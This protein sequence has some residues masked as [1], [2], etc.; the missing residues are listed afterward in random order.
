ME[1]LHFSRD[2]PESITVIAYDITERKKM[3]E[4]LR[5]SEKKF[6]E[7]VK[8]APTAIYELDFK[9]RKFTTVN[10]AMCQLSGYSREELLSMDALD[11]LVPKSK[12]LFMSRIKSC[13][14]G[15]KPMKTW[16]MK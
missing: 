15:E 10:D 8:F 5:E 13:F 9:K 11:L 6:R 4:A 2:V 14:N 1:I 3:E 12:A 16:N 7:L